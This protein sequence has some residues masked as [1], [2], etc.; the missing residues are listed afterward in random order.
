MAAP[1][2]SGT[3]ALM[4]QANPAL[5]PNAVKAILQF[6]AEISCGYDPLTEGAGFLNARGRR[7]AREYLA[8]RRQVRI[9]TRPAGEPHSSGA[10]SWCGRPTHRR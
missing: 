3:V 2:V 7:R 5:T 8:S 1:V 4:L 9:P 6:T 10:T